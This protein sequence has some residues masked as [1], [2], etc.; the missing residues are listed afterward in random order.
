MD[1][2]LLNKIL[3]FVAGFFSGALFLTIYL[4]WDEIKYTFSIW[5]KGRN[6]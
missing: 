1:E 4:C 5:R 2:I 6:G 3:L